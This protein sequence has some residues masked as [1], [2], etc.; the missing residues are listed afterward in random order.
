MWD[1][2]IIAVAIVTVICFS[3][4][5]MTLEA[6]KHLVLLACQLN[7]PTGLSA[8]NIAL[9]GSSDQAVIASEAVSVCTSLYS[10]V[11]AYDTG[12]SKTKGITFLIQIIRVAL[13]NY[14][15]L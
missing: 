9:H 13:H 5:G 11:Y 4:Q 14:Y 6:C 15:A 1:Q 12:C 8:F 7:V 2:Y 3:L 10:T